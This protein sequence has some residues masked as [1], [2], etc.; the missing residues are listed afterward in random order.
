MRPIRLIVIGASLGGPEALTQLLA[1]LPRETPPI[2][3][4]QHLHHRTGDDLAHNLCTATG[5]RLSFAEDKSPLEPSSILLAPPGYHLLV[6]DA[7]HVALSIDPP[8]HYCR[9]AVD[10]LFDSAAD[11]F[12]SSVAGVL[13]TGANKDGAVGLA[14]IQ[15]RGGAVLV[16]DPAT[17]CARQMPEAGLRSCRPDHVG[18]PSELGAALATMLQPAG[19]TG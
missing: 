17:A 19:E 15:A 7:E 3:V 18:S 6:E 14:S 11:A 2:A 13:L 4:A 9:P 5:R 10:V 8:V 12:G 16:Q 1:R